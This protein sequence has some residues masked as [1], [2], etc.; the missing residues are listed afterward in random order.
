MNQ[1][2]LY[3]RA[4]RRDTYF[5]AGHA[6]IA[7]LGA[8]E[9]VRLSME[10]ESDASSWMEIQEPILNKARLRSSSKAREEAKSIIRALL[11]GPA[12]QIRYSFG[13]QPMEFNLSNRFL[14]DQETIWRA[15]SLAAKVA[16]DSPVLIHNLWNEVMDV[17]GSAENWAA[18]DAVATALL[19]NGELA[20]CEVYEIT[21]HAMGGCAGSALAAPGP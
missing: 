4:E 5:T 1:N 6:V 16:K 11:A 10:W 12:A 9:V 8:L 20:G 7:V 15:I 17:L 13:Y 14:I 18:V 3:P 2:W 21:R 19:S